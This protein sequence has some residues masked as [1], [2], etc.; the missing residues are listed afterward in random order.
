V[1]VAYEPVRGIYH[2]ADRPDDLD[3]NYYWTAFCG[4]CGE[5]IDAAARTER[6]ARAVILAAIERDYQPIN[7]D[8]IERRHRGLIYI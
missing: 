1:T 3:L 4:G 5:E 6:E 7:I 2:A 8:R